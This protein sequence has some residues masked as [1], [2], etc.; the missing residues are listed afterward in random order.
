MENA[1]KP[2]TG[3]VSAQD[4]AA[5]KKK[6]TILLSKWGF[7]LLMVAATAC[8]LRAI[9]LGSIPYLLVSMVL[10]GLGIWCLKIWF[11]LR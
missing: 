1:K 2:E 6:Q 10:L 11:S 4:Q 5:K 9:F 3:S 7:I 8:S